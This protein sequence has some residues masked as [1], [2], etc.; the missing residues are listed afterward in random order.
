MSADGKVVRRAA[1]GLYSARAG[2]RRVAG[3]RIR[4]DSEEESKHLCLLPCIKV[5]VSV[6]CRWGVEREKPGVGDKCET[7]RLK[8]LIW[9]G[10]EGW[11]MTR[12]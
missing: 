10:R 4:V 8:V 12:Q 6:R 9:G 11:M 3:R 7:Q 2:L 1:A 5:V